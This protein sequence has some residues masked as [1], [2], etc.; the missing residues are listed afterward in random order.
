MD[1]HVGFRCMNC[2]KAY[3]NGS[4]RE[5]SHSMRKQMALGRKM[6]C[7][8]LTLAGLLG[9]AGCGGT[10]PGTT[11]SCPGGPPEYLGDL[12]DPGQTC[13]SSLTCD[14]SSLPTAGLCSTACKTASDCVGKFG[15]NSMCI[16]ASR[17][18]V[19]CRSTADCDPGHFCNDY[20]WCARS[21]CSS[22]AQCWLYKCDTVS[23][24]CK[25]SCTS[26][27]DCQTGTTC[28]LTLKLCY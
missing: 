2:T 11:P 18:V 27:A 14:N 9:W 19:T 1:G 3:I 28:E 12:C 4:I 25:K 26:N 17:C 5:R 13:G 20:H 24:S 7:H 21:N 23:K 16:G 8:V 6:I 22:D 15:P 10:D